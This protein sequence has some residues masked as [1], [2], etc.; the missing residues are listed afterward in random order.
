MDVSPSRIKVFGECANQYRYQYILKLPGEQKGALTV[1]GTV[2]HYAAQVYE[3]YDNDIDLAVQTFRY[4]WNHAEELGEKIDWY[5]PRSS[6][7]SLEERG[8]TMLE[9][10]HDLAPWKGGELVGTEVEFVVPLGQNHNIRGIIDKLFY[11]PQKREL[12]IIDF[13]TGLRV[14]KKLRYNLQFTC[15][16]YATTRPEFWAK[17]PG[18]EDFWP[19]AIN[20]KRTGQWYHARENKTFNVGYRDDSDYRRLL[21]AVDQMEAAIEADIFP[22]TIEGEACGWCSWRD[23]CGTEVSSPNTD[24]EEAHA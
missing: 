24:L 1:L 13:K 5:P 11:R 4:Y 6:H 9:R 22:L 10:Y 7:D 18:W 12:Q 8:V 15:Y 17:V 3:L 2:F 20:L 16:L 21:L 23:D 14:P 19:K